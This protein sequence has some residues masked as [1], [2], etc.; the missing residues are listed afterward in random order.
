MLTKSFTSRVF[1]SVNSRDYLCSFGLKSGFSEMIAIVVISSL[2]GPVLSIGVVEQPIRRLPGF[3]TNYARCLLSVGERAAASG[4]Y[5]VSCLG[6]TGR[7][8]CRAMSS[9]DCSCIK[10]AFRLN[11]AKH[12]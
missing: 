5:Q 7:T 2:L 9:S 1:S 8:Y 12:C 11:L 3:F 4:S 10:V 6:A